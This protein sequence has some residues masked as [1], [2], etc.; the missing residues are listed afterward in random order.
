MSDLKPCP[1][2]GGKVALYRNK[3]MQHVHVMHAD[4][5]EQ[6][7]GWY[8][9]DCP[10]EETAEYG[11]DKEKMLIEHWNGRT[12]PIEDALR[13]QNDG[14]YTAVKLAQGEQDALRERIKELEEALEKADKAI[15]DTKA[16]AEM[17]EGTRWQVVAARLGEAHRAIQAAKSDGEE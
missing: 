16:N 7:E 9:D 1:F 2:C 13:E 10:F 15:L 11:L 6:D 8:E 12:R 3:V 14:L 4:G 17:P 5:D